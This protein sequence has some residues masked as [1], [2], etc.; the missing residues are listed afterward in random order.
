M[1]L[2]WPLTFQDWE[3]A[4]DKDAFLL[5]AAAAYKLTPAFRTALDAA[6]YFRGE[7][8]AVARKTVLRAVKVETRDEHGRR[9]SR[10]EA[11]EVVGNRVASGFLSRF[12]T[13]QTQFLLGSGVQLPDPALKR[14]LGGDFDRVLSHIGERALLH[15]VCYCYWNGRRAEPVEAV[16]DERS[17]CF[18]LPDACTGEIRAAVQFWQIAEDR[19]LC[20]RL[21]QRDR[22]TLLEA[23]DGR[24]RPLME[25]PNP[26]PGFPLVPFWANTEHV[27]EFTPAIRSKIDAYDRILSDLADN[28]DRANDVYWVLNNFGGTIDDVAELMEQISRVKA[29]TAL[30]D[31]SGAAA[32]AEPRTISVPYE[33]RLAALGLLERALY[34][35]WMAL[36][37]QEVTGGNLTNV[38][39][40]T[41]AA[42]LNLKADRFEW[43]AFRF[44]RALLLLLG[45][46]VQDIRFPR[47]TIANE[48]EIVKD[49]AVMRPDI[50]RETAV[51]LNP[52]LRKTE[53][54]GC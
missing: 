6:R 31:G 54:S 10:P 24:L 33:A 41:A 9:R 48:S 36:D 13:Q 21:F 5:A 26:C 18:T 7:N 37:M 43:E 12:V 34:R 30:S 2:R 17:G 51:R 50:D 47:Q 39:I 49:I 25:A 53:S 27:S 29:V 11:R 44:M 52:Y 1:R 46:D 35:D 40:R 4:E 32:S 42:N 45:A 3:A 16:R 23:R 20:L 22:V 14:R 19:P 38:A 15:G 8:T 28:L